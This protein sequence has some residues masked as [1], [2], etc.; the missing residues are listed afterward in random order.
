[1]KPATI[2][3]GALVAVGVPLA[4][5]LATGEGPSPTVPTVVP[6]ANPT[7]EQVEASRRA[8]ATV[9]AVLTH[10]RCSNCHPRDGVPTQTMKQRPHAMNISRLS[11]E[12][13]LAC[14]TCHQAVN[15]ERLGIPG[16][17]PGAP[18]WGLPP[19]EFPAPFQGHTA[20]SLCEQLRDPAKNGNRDL[21]ALHQHM[22]SDPLVLWAWK[23]G[24]TRETPPV[25]HAVFAAAVAQ[26]VIGGG[27]CPPAPPR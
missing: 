27:A 2:L 21:A 26:W 9:A 4:T 18:H 25:T 6:A 16:G 1:M 5:A 23:P 22:A 17:P 7:P 3:C 14:S 24:G 13:G 15:S 20:S 8:F 11:I 10:P 12:S 19:R